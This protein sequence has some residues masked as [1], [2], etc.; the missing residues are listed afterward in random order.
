MNDIWFLEKKQEH[1]LL[2]MDQS[3]KTEDRRFL[4]RIRDYFEEIA[5]RP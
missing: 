2:V 1:G 5:E 4:N 3:D